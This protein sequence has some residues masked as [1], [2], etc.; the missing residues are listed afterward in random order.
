MYF[1]DLPN[2]SDVR[3]EPLQR[4]VVADDAAKIER[5]VA[6]HFNRIGGLLQ[7][8]ANQT[9][10]ALPSLLA[11]WT[12][13]SGD[14]PFIVGQPVLRFEVHKF[15]QHW[16][17]FNQ[18][19]FDQHLQF[20]GRAGIVGSAWTGHK[21]F[22]NGNWC[23]F[24]GDQNLERAT[25]Q[26]AENLGG[27]EA[28]CLSSSFGGPQILGSNFHLLGYP[29]AATMADAFGQSETWQVCGFFDYCQHHDLISAL[30][31]MDWLRFATGYN[32]L[33]QA[34]AYAGLIAEAF[35]V[36]TESLNVT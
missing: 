17:Q 19:A 16:G 24:H 27:L 4:I 14:L 11:V 32:G 20:G 31:E 7:E 33:G 12:V 15:F 8:L 1:K 3:Q 5:R 23:A 28:A 18:D 13:E 9:S 36:A 22:S 29:S 6:L 21:L 2:I 35:A 26:V 30:R 25:L 10:I 34:L